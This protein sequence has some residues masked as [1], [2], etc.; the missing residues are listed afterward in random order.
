MTDRLD[1]PDPHLDPVV[2]AAYDSS[3]AHEFA[4]EFVEAAVD[5]L[6]E[7][8]GDGKAVEFAIG[9]GRLALPLAVRGTRYLSG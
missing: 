1:L 5:V 7:F 2:A 4:P 8:A 6:A 9:T 3:S